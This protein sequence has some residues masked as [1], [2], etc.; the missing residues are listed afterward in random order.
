MGVAHPSAE[1]TR[2]RDSKRNLGQRDYIAAM[3]MERRGEWWY[4]TSADDLDE[5]LRAATSDGYAVRRVVPAT[6]AACAGGVFSV[7]VDDEQGYSERTCAACGDRFE[8]LDSADYEDESEAGDAECLCGEDRFDVA[9][10]FAFFGD[11]ES[12]EVRWV[13]VALRCVVCGLMGVYA[14]WKIDYGPSRQLLGQV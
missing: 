3:V 11:D 9:A 4:A 5:Y 8:M 12:G 1:V 10:G 13:S 6:C 2:G 14:D 7:C